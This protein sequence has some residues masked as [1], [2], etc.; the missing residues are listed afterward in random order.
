M[1]TDLTPSQRRVVEYPYKPNSTLKVTA[2]PGSGKTFTL[3]RKVHHLITTGQVKPEEILV[4]SLT[5]KAVDNIVDKLLTV[6]EQA[7]PEGYPK[8]GRIEGHCR[9][10]NR[11]HNSQSG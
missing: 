8:P 6:F 9:K 11:F 4:L 1:G 2:G 7:Q 3:L 10:D 5:N